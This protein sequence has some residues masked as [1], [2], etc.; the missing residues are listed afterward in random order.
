[1]SF[2]KKGNVAFKQKR[3]KDALYFYEKSIR[4]NPQIEEYIT[5][6]LEQ[7]KSKLGVREGATDST[8]NVKVFVGIAA[9]PERVE[10]LR[11]T[12]ESLIDQ[13][14]LIGVYLNNWSSVPEFL[15]HE[16]ILVEGV[17]GKDIGDI[18][19]FWWVNRVKGVYF[20]CDDDLLYPENYVQ[21]TI[22]ALEKYNYKAVVG[23]HGSLLKE[24]F[25]DYYDKASRRVF[26]FSAHR[27]HDTPVH[28]LGTGCCAFDTTKFLIRYEDFKSPNMADVYFAEK[29]QLSKTPFY[30][31]KHEKN[32]V[33]EIEGYKESSIFMHSHKNV[34]SVK[35]TT[36]L[37]NDIVNKMW[38]WKLND[39]LGLNVL[40]IGRFNTYS[41]G[42]IYKSCKLIQETL[43][44]LG[45]NV[46]VLDTTEELSSEIAKKTYDLCWIYPGDPIRPDYKHVDEKIKKIRNNGTPV[47]VNFSYLSS[48][49]RTTWI[50]KQLKYYNSQSGAPVLAAV[51]TET[52]AN[53]VLLRDVREYVCV[54][55]KTIDPTPF[56]LDLSYSVR[57]GICLGD[58]TKLSNPDII[59]GS[60]NP[61][62]DAISNR[63]PHVNLYAYKQ[64]SGKDP[65]PKVKYVPH[66]QDEFGEFL[67]SRRLFI[68]LNVY[69]TFEM[70]AC[71]SQSYGTPVVYRH[72]PH[73][74]SEY[75]SATG[76]CVRTPEEMAEMV[77]WLY[78]NEE[79][80]YSFSS[81]SSLNAKSKM[82]DNYKYSLEGYLRLAS[83]RATLLKSALV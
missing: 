65:H 7:V 46:D 52:A 1:M 49:D 23:W 32:E 73:S 2:L 54:L 30:V 10:A 6:N 64:Y 81:S 17:G 14:D 48:D 9:I 18:G 19:K 53:D 76:L 63:L 33:I 50:A 67:A 38:P 58:A 34:S 15:K 56:D 16:K 42:G 70:V 36:K 69:L 41:K 57:E 13:V 60:V 68:C 45:H 55:P 79:A 22:A 37:Q 31:I 12:I 28:I 66:M 62:I 39:F 40:L 75:I 29:G 77:A 3:Y 25:K 61:W 21:K 82:I 47:L 71:E 83:K 78:N 5:Y 4:E 43:I 20:T 80:W 24:P 26:V 74:L 44:G 35:N 59:G 27:P 8:I 72:M 51:F 11:K